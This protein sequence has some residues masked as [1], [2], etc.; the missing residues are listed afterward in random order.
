VQ[1]HRRNGW[2]V[3]GAALIAAG[4]AWLAAWGVAV[5][6][7]SPPHA[8]QYW[9]PA[10]YV[11]A[12]LVAAGFLVVVAVMYDW[13]ARPRWLSPRKAELP[14]KVVSGKPHY[15]DW[16]H[17]ASVAALPV[18]ITNM[19]RGPVVLPGGCR[20][21]GYSGDT[22]LWE[23]RLTE[24]ERGLFVREIASQERS[25]HHLPNITE[26]ATIPARASLEV[27][28]VTDISRDQRGAR[29]RITL[30]FND[31]EGNEYAAAFRGQEPRHAQSFPGSA[32]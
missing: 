28:Y 9:V 19:T 2:Y 20:S 11:A 1:E 5:D 25:S 8:L 29:P 27:W 3:L 6:S 7:A 32:T 16:N 15:H 14:L 12:G 13:P 17:A 21:E 4:A 30:Y 23:S 10:S 22:P 18:M 26:R 31:S 24:D